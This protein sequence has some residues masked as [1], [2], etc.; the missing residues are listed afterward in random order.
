[1]HWGDWRWH[2]RADADYRL[3]LGQQA[4]RQGNL[5]GASRIAVLLSQ[6]TTQR[7]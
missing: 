3:G 2:F 1:L 6:R 4:L 5:E 7:F